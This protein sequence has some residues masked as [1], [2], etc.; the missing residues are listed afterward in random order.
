MELTP[1]LKPVEEVLSR[2]RKEC[3]GGYGS[4]EAAPI[5]DELQGLL[6]IELEEALKQN[7]ASVRKQAHDL[8]DQC[9]QQAK[10]CEPVRFGSAMV[11]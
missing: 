8:K 11:V 10:V 4:E 1:T 6:S 2:F 9:V 7:F 3:V 5:L